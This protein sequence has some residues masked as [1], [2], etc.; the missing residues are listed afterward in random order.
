M[1]I[2]DVNLGGKGSDEVASILR[3]AG[4]KVKLVISRIVDEEPPQI[5]VRPDNV[6]K[7]FGRSTILPIL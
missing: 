1:Q 7:T 4:N 6:S 3:K 5:P 2:N